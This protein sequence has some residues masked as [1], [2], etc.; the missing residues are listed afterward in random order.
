[1]SVIELAGKEI[2][3]DDEGYLTNSEDWSPDVAQELARREDMEPLSDEQLS[4]IRFM[5][6]YYAKFNAFPIL[7][8]VCKNV[9]QPR[10]C[11]NEE[12]INPEKAWKLAGLPKL[13]GVHFVTM[14]GKNYIMEECC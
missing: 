8:H 11:V 9:H 12:F 13:S 6:D 7:N 3:L 10:E 1:M 5:R 4:I 2:N 14:D